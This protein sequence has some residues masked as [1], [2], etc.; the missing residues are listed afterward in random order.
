MD[1]LSSR[2]LVSPRDFDRAVRFYTQILGLHVYREYGVGGRVT[3]MVLFLGGGF[4]ELTRAGR[5]APTTCLW[6]QVADVDAEHERLAA[7]GVAITEPPTDMPWGLREMQATD[8]E[9]T[10]LRIVEIPDRH[11]LRWRVD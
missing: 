11:P 1:V 10:V 9:G 4:L 2:V 6:L 3:G 5:F 8:P 7:A